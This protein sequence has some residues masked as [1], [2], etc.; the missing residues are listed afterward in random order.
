MDQLVVMLEEVASDGRLAKATAKLMRQMYEA[1][2]EEGFT[3]EEAITLV[4]A[5][6]FTS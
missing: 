3:P 6:K 4:S 2:I 1:F 5:Q